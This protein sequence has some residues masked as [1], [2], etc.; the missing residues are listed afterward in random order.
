MRLPVTTIASPSPHSR[1]SGGGGG[2]ALHRSRAGCRWSR[3]CGQHRR[4]SGPPSRGSGATRVAVELAGHG[5]GVGIDEAGLVGARQRQPGEQVDMRRR[6]ATELG[7]I[8][9]LP[10][11]AGGEVG[12]RHGRG[13]RPRRARARTD[14]VGRAESPAGTPS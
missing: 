13:H 12:E 1:R 14:R 9:G 2:G 7:D 8:I 4:L 5:L 11:E 6:P 10:V 3:A